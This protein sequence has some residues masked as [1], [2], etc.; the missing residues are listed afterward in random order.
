MSVLSLV[1]SFGFALAG[2]GAQV[3][4][5]PTIEFL[6]GY[7]PLRTKGTAIAFALFAAI[8]AVIGFIVGG[9]AIDFGMALTLAVGATIGT[10]L[11]VKL[12]TEPK[13]AIVR[14]TGQSIGIAVAVYV[15]GEAMRHRI[16]GPMPILPALQH[17][18][19]LLLGIG[20]GA[21]TGAVSNIFQIAN[22]ILVVPALVYLAG[23]DAPRSV[24]TSLAVI[25]FAGF[26]PALS[27]SA[28]GT[29]DKTMGTWMSSAGLAGG[30]GAGMLL[31]HV[32]NTSP[33]PLIAFA[34]VSMFLCAWRIWKMT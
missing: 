5:A 14:R 7:T 17:L 9:V 11:T 34:L 19:P 23:M 22:G 31:S 26:L 1:I 28:R 30:F 3:A 27:Y 8:G 4:A 32:S 13:F 18:N 21:V 33:L 12:G 24:V 6:L 15:F 29:V 16:G 10:I 20:I 25:A 2:I